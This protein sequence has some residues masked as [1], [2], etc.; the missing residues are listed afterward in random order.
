MKELRNPVAIRKLLGDI[1]EKARLLGRTPRLMEV[2]GTHTM[3]LFKH[4]LVPLL[5]DAGVEM[6]SGP[7]CPVCIT[8]DG[9]HEAA[10]GLVSETE[11]LTLATFGDMTRVPTRNGSLQTA[12]PG[13]GSRI[14]IV[15]S[16]EEALEEARRDPSRRVV[17]F[18]AGFETTIPAIAFTAKRAAAE[19]IRNFSI[20]PALWLVPP[21]LKA[22]LEAGE[23]AVTGF[24]YPGHVSAIIGAEPYEFIAR[25]Y[26]IPGAIAGFEPGD[27]LLA[28]RSILE[29]TVEGKP[30]VALEYSRAIGREGNPVARALME[31]VLEPF[32]AVWRG[33]GTIP[34]SGLRFRKE[35]AGLDA[36][37]TYGLKPGEADRDLPGCRCGDVLRGVIRPEGCRLFGKECRPDSPLGPCMVSYEG[38]CLIHFKYGRERRARP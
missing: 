20:L 21:A 23:I 17:F 19:G 11:G 12:V 2:C 9:I 16:P 33:L 1:E 7:G 38:A 28:V 15:Y 35:F 6:V 37:P 14:R 26:G 32:D 5:A 30:R 4:G 25:D 13:R 31:E 10:I 18:G 29:Q 24:V 36:A 27:I 22:I 8:P 3:S 34:R